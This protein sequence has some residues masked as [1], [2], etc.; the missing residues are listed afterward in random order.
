[1]NE[2]EKFYLA[3][4][5]LD[6]LQMYAQTAPQPE[7]AI[8]KRMYIQEKLIPE[9]LPHVPHEEILRRLDEIK[10]L[11]LTEEIVLKYL[12]PKVDEYKLEDLLKK[13][14]FSS[15]DDLR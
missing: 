6:C 8:M 14:K 2:I 13:A 3:M 1:M 10:Q 11:K 5:F 4:G 7:Q 12:K 9:L 15:L